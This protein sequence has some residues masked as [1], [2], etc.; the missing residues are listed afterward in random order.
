MVRFAEAAEATLGEPID[1]V[2]PL[3]HRHRAW[4]LVGITAYLTASFLLGAAGVYGFIR[5]AISGALAGLAMTALSRQHLLVR[6]NTNLWLIA[7]RPFRSR[8]DVVIGRVTPNDVTTTDGKYSDALYIG[9][10]RYV[11]PR[12]FRAQAAELIAPTDPND[13]SPPD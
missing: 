10:T 3:M 1:A 9:D 4:L 8:P 5:F 7:A 13:A 6:A 12:L 2:V 11:L